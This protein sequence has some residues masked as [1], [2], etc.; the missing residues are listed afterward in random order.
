MSAKASR[1]DHGRMFGWGNF[2]RVGWGMKQLT[3][4]TE[5][6]ERYAKATRRAAFLDE[7]DRVVPWPALCRLID[8]SIGN[9]VMAARRLA[10]SGC[11]TSIFCRTQSLF[12]Q[13]LRQFFRVR[14]HRLGGLDA[15]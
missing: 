2:A 9:R 3:L 14:M 7:M 1:A 15:V 5:E 4:A 12:N 8:R 13:C 6:F 11:C 10:S